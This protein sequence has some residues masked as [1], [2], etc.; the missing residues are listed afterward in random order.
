LNEKYRRKR[1][2]VESNDDDESEWELPPAQRRKFLVPQGMKTPKKVT[3]GNSGLLSPDYSPMGAEIR[4]M[5]EKRKA[6]RR[7]HEHKAHY[8]TTTACGAKKTRW[9]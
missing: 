4:V 3:R 5:A 8:T 6:E 9:A 1:V 7:R 2:Y